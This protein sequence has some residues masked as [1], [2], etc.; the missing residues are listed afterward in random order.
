MTGERILREQTVVV[1]DGLINAVGPAKRF[2]IPPYATRINGRGKY[3]LPGL[4][5]MHAH[6]FSDD[7]FP[8]ELA[9]EELTV[10]ARQRC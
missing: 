4:T 1:R 7:Q 6:L 2:K 8:D 3:L 9:D 5:D 10:H